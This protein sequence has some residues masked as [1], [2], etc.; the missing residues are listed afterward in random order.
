MKGRL[1]GGLFYFPEVYRN[2][3]ISVQKLLQLCLHFPNKVIHNC[4]FLVY[5]N[6][7]GGLLFFLKLKCRGR[8]RHTPLEC[9][10]LI[11]GPTL[12]TLQSHDFSKGPFVDV[13]FC[14]ECRR[15]NKVTLISLD[16]VPEME[17]LPKGTKINFIDFSSVF[18]F[19]KVKRNG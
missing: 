11:G 13:R 5:I 6:F 14:H 17:V 3:G 19:L 1:P 10:T 16:G 15:W 12:E 18:R 2:V 9:R 8:Q 4:T 7:K